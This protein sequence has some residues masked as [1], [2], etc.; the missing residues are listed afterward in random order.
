MTLLVK[1]VTQVSLLGMS[2]EIT[3]PGYHKGRMA[4]NKGKKYPPEVL[5]SE[6]IRCLIS[7][8]SNRAPTGIRNRALIAVMY[9]GGLRLGEALSLKP[10]DIDDR[11]GTVAVLHG[12]GGKR[13][14]VG[15]DPGALAMVTRWIER[16]HDLD[17]GP[18][19]PL[20]CTLSGGK[21]HQSYVRTLLPRLA[22]K[23]GIEKR[24]HPHGLRHAMS[25]ELMMEAVPMPI[26]QRQL[27]HSSL[28][29][30]DRYL[31]WIAPMDV[32]E[33]MQQRVWL[34]DTFT[35]TDRSVEGRS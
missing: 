31:Q 33:K 1:S 8:A 17:V 9:R 23:A 30:T 16:R 10:K 13:R 3:Q 28:A 19:Q 34:H 32:I 15:L 18:H 26:I 2:N 11:R 20:F 27:G 4:P 22:S 25:Y 6:E 14:T 24:V 5:T 21:L 12:K 35:E 7:A 29:T